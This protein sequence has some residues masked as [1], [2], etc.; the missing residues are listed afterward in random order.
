MIPHIRGRIFYYLTIFLNNPAGRI[1]AAVQLADLEVSSRNNFMN[2][3]QLRLDCVFIV[4]VSNIFSGDQTLGSV[5]LTTAVTTIADH[6]FV[7]Y[8][9]V[10]SAKYT[11]SSISSLFIPS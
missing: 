2:N 11:P 8:N 3:E 1:K 6:A 9:N 5:C 7:A 10:S 4:L